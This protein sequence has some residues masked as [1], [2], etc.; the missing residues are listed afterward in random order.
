LPGRWYTYIVSTLH[1]LRPGDRAPEFTLHGVTRDVNVSLADYRGKSAVLLGLFRGLHC[2]FCRR[3]I[4][5]LSGMHD[6]LVGM[7]ITTVAVVN[8][9]RQRAE[10][11]FRYHPVRLVLLA[12][13]EAR[14]HQAFGV[15]SVVPDDAF[16]AARV[17]PTGELPAAMHPMEANSVLNA[18]DGFV[19]T[20]VDEEVFRAHGT[21]LGGHFLIDRDGIVRW[22]TIEAE[23]GVADLARFP[24]PREIVSAARGLGS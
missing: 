3:Q 20:R 23:H 21:Q 13:P 7:D 6:T 18:K 2:P 15:P 9:P 19:L 17:N 11:Y 4:F 8:T 12:D 5:Q 16:A 14:T 10:L 22:S 1:T 24:A